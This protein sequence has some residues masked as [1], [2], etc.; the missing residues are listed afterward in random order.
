MEQKIK[1]IM[2]DLL[3]IYGFDNLIEIGDFRIYFRKADEAF[4]DLNPKA[5]RMM[6]I[7]TIHYLSIATLK[8]AHATYTYEFD[9]QNGRIRSIRE[10]KYDYDGNLEQWFIDNFMPVR[11]LQDHVV[12]V[13]L[14]NHLDS[15]LPTKVDVPKEKKLK[16]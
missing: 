11:E 4:V 2:N 12:K 9:Y 5:K 15:Q 13:K 1:R 16:I 10:G 14:H 8:Q 7:H 3:K 6:N